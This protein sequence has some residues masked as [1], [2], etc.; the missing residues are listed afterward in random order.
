MLGVH[1]VFATIVADFE[2]FLWAFLIQCKTI[3]P[4]ALVGNE[5]VPHSLSTCTISYPPHACGIIVKYIY[6]YIRG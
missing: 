1:V 4:F 5:I 2:A 3:I 6:N